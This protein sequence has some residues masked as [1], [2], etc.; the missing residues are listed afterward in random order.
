[1]L[2]PIT[3][4]EYLIMLMPALSAYYIIVAALCYR[5][6]IGGM[7]SK[8]RKDFQPTAEMDGDEAIASDIR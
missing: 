5:K 4:K 1:M 7:I 3:W 2:K 8:Q 6:E